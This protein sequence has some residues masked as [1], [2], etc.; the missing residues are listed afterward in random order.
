MSGRERKYFVLRDPLS[1][2]EADSLL[3][4]LVTS[5]TSPLDRFAPC[6]DP[7]RPP[8]NTNDILPCI[9]PQP[10]I[11]TSCDQTITIAK[12][13]GFSVQLSALLNVKLSRNGEETIRLESDLVK[14]YTL[15]SPEIDFELLMENEDYAKDARDLLEKTKGNRAYFITG[16]ITASEA[17]WSTEKTTGRGGGFDSTVPTGQACGIPDSGFL[18]IGFGANRFTSNTQS[19]TRYIAQEHIFAISYHTVE[20]SSKRVWPSM[21]VSY[22]TVL[23]GPKKAKAYHLAM[24]TGDDDDLGEVEWDSDDEDGSV[25]ELKAE[26][27]QEEQFEVLLSKII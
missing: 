10:D 12:D 18:N 6:P 22:S 15:R 11:S 5:T 27:P 19:Y 24:G 26:K 23:T 3:G 7:R 16:F 2:T 13:H 9:L 4:R 1:V 17:T 21:D 14:K 20:L 25:Y 8:H